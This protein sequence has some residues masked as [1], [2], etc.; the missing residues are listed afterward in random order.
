M[1]SADGIRLLP[2]HLSWGGGESA[3]LT[4]RF[5]PCESLLGKRIQYCFNPIECVAADRTR[6]GGFIQVYANP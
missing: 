4:G 3:K 1:R 6:S 2:D 5:Y